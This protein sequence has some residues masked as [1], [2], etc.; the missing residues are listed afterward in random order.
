MNCLSV[1][2][3]CPV[4]R[5]AFPWWAACRSCQHQ[6]FKN[7]INHSLDR[8]SDYILIIIILNPRVVV[9]DSRMC[10]LKVRL[11]AFII[12]HFHVSLQV[13]LA[14]LGCPFVWT[15]FSAWGGGGGG[16]V[17][18][19]EYRVIQS[20]TRVYLSFG[21]WWLSIRVRSQQAK[22]DCLPLPVVTVSPNNMWTLGVRIHGWKMCHLTMGKFHGNCFF[23]FFFPPPSG[24]K[25]SILI[26][27]HFSL[28]RFSIQATFK[29]HFQ[30]PSCLFFSSLHDSPFLLGRNATGR[31]ILDLYHRFSSWATHKVTPREKEEVSSTNV[32]TILINF[33][34][35]K[36][37]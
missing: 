37:A 36:Q 33:G 29:S 28:C 13:Q 27:H 16:G 5:P 14:C 22:A 12:C 30:L 3:I 24:F 23:F 25:P 35:T 9:I 34:T 10:G 7:C 6:K 4:G 2:S 1:I 21:R 18:L 15:S 26:L 17:Q 31:S 32:G 19:S 20:H 11:I 8:L